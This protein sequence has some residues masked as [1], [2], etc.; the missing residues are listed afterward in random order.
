MVDD[1]G[2][3]GGQLGK[4]VRPGRDVEAAG[5]QTGGEVIEHVVAR[6]MAER[7]QERSEKNGAFGALAEARSQEVGGGGEDVG[8]AA[9]V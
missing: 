5:G 9:S 7:H 6:V 1:E 2:A 8:A 3:D 4:G